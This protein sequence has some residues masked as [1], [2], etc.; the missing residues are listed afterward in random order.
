MAAVQ[1]TLKDETGKVYSRLTVL[2]FSHCDSK[3]KALWLCRCECGTERAILGVT[4][5]R[6]TARSCGCSRIRHGHA[7]RVK[8][9]TTEYKS[10]GAML[11]RCYCEQATGYAMYGARGIIVCDRWRES[12]ENFYADMGPKPTDR[13]SIERNDGTGNYEPG[14][15]KW[16]TSYEQTRNVRRN[17][18]LS[19]EG[20]TMCITDW[21]A[22]FGISLS[23]FKWRYKRHGAD[24]KIFT[25]ERLPKE[26]I[27]RTHR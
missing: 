9:K 4:L 1:N 21:A 20:K 16:A 27:C 8:G 12:F 26:R 7:R 15:C 11:S 22:H 10:W 14:N 6:G 24:P 23:G 19:F 18:M 3:G 13:H 5:R 17:V 25:R 2:G